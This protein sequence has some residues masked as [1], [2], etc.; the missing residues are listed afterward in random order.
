M[1]T[2]NVQSIR[3]DV[4][5]ISLCCHCWVTLCRRLH[6]WRATFPSVCSHF[7]SAPRYLFSSD[8]LLLHNAHSTS[9]IE[10]SPHHIVLEKDRR[11]LPSSH[12]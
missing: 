5:V 3:L 12:S 2:D 8:A 10:R 7:T 9:R 6:L 4:S 11:M 1:Q